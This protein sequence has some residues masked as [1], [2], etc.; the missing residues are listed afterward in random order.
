MISEKQLSDILRALSDSIEGIANAIEQGR[1]ADAPPPPA[2]QPAQQPAPQEVQVVPFTLPS[3]PPPAQQPAQQA[4]VQQ[5]PVQ[6][7]PVQQA[8]MEFKDVA[9]KLGIIAQSL[10]EAG[11]VRLGQLIHGY[12]VPTL[13]ALDAQH[14]PDLLAKAEALVNG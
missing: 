14:Y 13:S 8:P 9:K 5:A 3:Q 7:A 10:D 2:Q 6:Q 1:P 12:G 11:K 4:P